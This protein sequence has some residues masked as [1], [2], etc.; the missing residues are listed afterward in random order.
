MLFKD[1]SGDVCT[2]QGLD[3]GQILYVGIT[4][5]VVNGFMIA[6][7]V[8][9]I[10]INIFFSVNYYKR[11]FKAEG[12]VSTIEY[13]LCWVASIEVF[14]S[15]C[16]LL[17]NAFMQNTENIK[18]RCF[19]CKGIAHIE[20]FLYLFNWMILSASLYQI[21]RILYDAKNIL[22][23]IKAFIY[24]IL[25]CLSISLLSFAF[26]ISLE[27][28]G[29]S[30][31]LT[32]FINIENLNSTTKNVF[33]WIFFCLPLFCFGFGGYQIFSIIKSTQYQSDKDFFKEY[34]Y[35]ILIHSFFSI[36][37]I[38]CYIM[39]YIELKIKE[40]SI[41]K[42]SVYD[43]IIAIITFLCCSTP[44]IVGLFRV[45]RTDFIRSLLSK[46]KNVQNEKDDGLIPVDE[47][48]KNEGSRIF[49]IEK[50]LLENLILK[51]FIAVSYSLGKSKNNNGENEEG[52]ENKV[53]NEEGNLFNE[54]EQMI[55]NI[56]KANILKDLDLAINEDIKVLE[57]ANINIKVTEYNS[58]LF[59]KL[60]KL[61]NLDED[62]I[63]GMIQPKKGTYQLL[64]KVKETFYINS[65]NKLLMLKQLKKENFDFFR[66]NI[67]NDLYEHLVNN[68]NSLICRVFGLYK[69]NI[70][71]TEDVYMALMYNIN[72]SL[73]TIDNTTVFSP[74]NEVRS[75]KINESEFRSC[76]K[77]D[78]NKLTD[79]LAKGN[80]DGTIVVGGS[81]SNANNKLFKINLKDNENERL[82]NAFNNDIEFLKKKT[83]LRYKF[84]VFERKIVN[85]DEISLF[86]NDE[87]ITRATR[88]SLGPASKFSS[89]IRKYVFDSN[90]PNEIYCI[91]ILD[92]FNNNRL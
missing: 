92:F 7:S 26:S 32:C 50:K 82:I 36:I 20:I 81:Q 42:D 89:N 76:I 1:N 55:Y 67:L 37:L 60:R 23:S 85:K 72:E 69:I 71:N 83:I 43:T 77:D 73:E 87:E 8:I 51:Y 65:S 59:K 46:G 74:N 58:S 64:K 11:I 27:I 61:E 53:Q 3:V 54:N 29:I 4:N 13:T 6:I 18:K 5:S 79:Q 75:M 21:R 80:F 16:W 88:A 45:Y 38:I 52:E 86:K 24:I 90:L 35:F 56:T 57:E 9:G 63:I 49:N 39:N 25:I 68:T 14:I 30:P 78:K 2:P 41:Y 47:D 28:G 15:L 10:C 91:C 84:L 40:K 70:D 12:G 22:N 66:K 48:I 44:L 19:W 17:N 62:K 33:F 34:F 31:L